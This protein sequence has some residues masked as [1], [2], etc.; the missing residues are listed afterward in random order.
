MMFAAELLIIFCFLRGIK[1][2]GLSR[3][4]TKNAAKSGIICLANPR[5]TNSN[6]FMADLQI[7]N[8]LRGIF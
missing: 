5:G 8:A 3:S 6:Q 2:M 4:Q 7:I 1:P